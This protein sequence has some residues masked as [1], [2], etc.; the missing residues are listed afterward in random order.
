MS[1]LVVFN[2]SR[3]D[4]K[5]APYLEHANLNLEIAKVVCKKLL[6][7]IVFLSSHDSRWINPAKFGLYAKVC[8]I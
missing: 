2:I 1:P 8:Q 6:S 4:I 3:P 5:M 7:E